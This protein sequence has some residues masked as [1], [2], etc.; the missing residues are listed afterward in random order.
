MKT[1]EG[2]TP[3]KIDHFLAKIKPRPVVALVDDDPVTLDLLDRVLRD[4]G[5]EVHRF[6]RAEDLLEQFSRLAPDAIVMEIILPGMNGVSVLDEIRPKSVEEIIPVLMLSKREDPRTKLL[7]FRK[8]ACDYLTK[9]FEAEEV[10]ARVRILIR[11]KIL[12]E[13]LRNYSI[14]DPLTSLY[15]RRFVLIWLE[16]EMERVKRYGLHL[17]CLLLDL[18][19]FEGVNNENGERF[20]DFILKEFGHV[21]KQNTRRADI[22]GRLQKDEFVVFLPGTSK[23][24]A[25][26]LARRLRALLANKT[27]R[28]GGKKLKVSFSAGIVGCQAQEAPGPSEFLAQVEEALRK[29]R[30]VGLGETAVL[31]M[32][33]S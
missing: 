10:A 26:I 3:S 17:A 19:G 24:Q 33:G 9:P 20:G 13:L 29:A 6:E 30:A 14:L 16:R 5:Y 4:E 22:V 1:R 27:F 25:M 21:L 2:L 12:Q 18:D 8:G 23:E 28:Q 15:N 31:G 32:N 7:A 11:M